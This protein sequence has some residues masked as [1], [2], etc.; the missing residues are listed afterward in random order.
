MKHS[1]QA[2]LF[3][4]A[5]LA[6]SAAHAADPA[7]APATAP[8]AAPAP[9][10]AAPVAEKPAVPAKLVAPVVNGKAI[11]QS[12][13][14]NLLAAQVAQGRPDTPELRKAV[15]DELVRRELL[16]QEANKTGVAKKDDVQAQM[17]MAQQS[18]LVSAYLQNYVKTHPVSEAAIK[19][20][21]DKLLETLGGKEYQVRH[22]LVETEDEAKAVVTKLKAGGKFE[23]LAKELSKDPGSKEKGGE[24][25]WANKAAYVK[26]F[27]D[28]MMALAKGKYTE[29]P[30]KSDFGF[31]II[32]LDDVRD[33]KAPP[34]DELK[35]RITQHLQQQMVE[36]H[37]SDLVAKAKVK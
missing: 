27:T 36:K 2:P 5:L 16:A 11:P 18:V 13:V 26:P 31:H 34:I 21:Y 8:A 29:T 14:D 35:P 19:A 20:E 4:A 6:V 24:L 9:A 1:L 3:A 12:R 33:L 17:A 32:Q 37:I 7:A 10:A 15:T 25:G 22:I 28:A 30:V 23:E